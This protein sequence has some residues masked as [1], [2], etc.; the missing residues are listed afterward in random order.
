MSEEMFGPEPEDWGTG[1]VEGPGGE[2][3]PS[4]PMDVGNGNFIRVPA[5]VIHDLFRMPGAV[6]AIKARATAVENLANANHITENAVYESVYVDNTGHDRPMVLV[7]PANFK[8]VLDEKWHSTLL[9]A[10]A[11][12]GSD[13]LVTP[14]TDVPEVEG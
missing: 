10:A 2:G 8:A 7:K 13:P 6:A 3:M 5:S 11:Q 1:P 4:G 9:A 14:G 12:V